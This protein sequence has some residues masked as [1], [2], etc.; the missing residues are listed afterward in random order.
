MPEGWRSHSLEA[1]VGE[2]SGIAIS[3]VAYPAVWRQELQRTTE[4]DLLSLLERRF[5][6]ARK[7]NQTIDGEDWVIIAVT[8]KVQPPRA[9]S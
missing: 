6:S 1:V 8:D 4:N 2:D 5:G 7:W 3:V 9:P